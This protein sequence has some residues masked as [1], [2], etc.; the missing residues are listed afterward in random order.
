MLKSFHLWL[1]DG[2]Y[3]KIVSNTH[4]FSSKSVKKK[5][6]K[7][8]LVKKNICFLFF[9]QVHVPQLFLKLQENLSIGNLTTFFNCKKT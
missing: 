3:G 2:R 1:E 5:K 4:T 6:K 9:F 7:K 8:L